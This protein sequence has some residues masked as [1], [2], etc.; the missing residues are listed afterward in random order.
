MVVGL[1]VQYLVA[2]LCFC[3]GIFLASSL[4][5]LPFYCFLLASVPYSAALLPHVH[6]LRFVI[7]SGGSAG[8]TY[9]GSMVRVVPIGLPVGSFGGSPDGNV[10]GFTF[11]AFAV[12]TI[13]SASV[14]AVADAVG[15]SV[16]SIAGKS[17]T[18]PCQ[19]PSLSA[20]QSPQLSP[21]P[22]LSFQPS[23]LSV[24]VPLHDRC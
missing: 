6:A 1:P 3:R 22:L 8:D 11:I 15:I 4:P 9:D 23:P 17:Q 10:V 24:C 18:T 21:L 12:V 16:A 20:A 13:A 2:V 14:A 5:W 19:V 7:R